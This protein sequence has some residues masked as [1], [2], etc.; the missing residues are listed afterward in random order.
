MRPHAGHLLASQMTI[1][2]YHRGIEE[3]VH[4]LRHEL[5]H[6]LGHDVHELVRESSCPRRSHVIAALLRERAMLPD[7]H[8]QSEFCW[9]QWLF[10]GYIYMR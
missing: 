3:E 4:D 6:E 7:S 2:W 10:S 8:T 1:P 9:P 5:V